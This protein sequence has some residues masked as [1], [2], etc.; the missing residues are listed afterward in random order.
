MNPLLE[1]IL[2]NG[3]CTGAMIYGQLLGMRIGQ[4]NDHTSLE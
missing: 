4:R 2:S 3:M 1:F